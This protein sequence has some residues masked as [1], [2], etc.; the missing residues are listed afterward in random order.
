MVEHHLRGHHIYILQHVALLLH[1][2]GRQLTGDLALAQIRER[3]VHI[4][5]LVANI[6]H[7]KD[8]LLLHLRHLQ[9]IDCIL[10]FALSFLT[11]LMGDATV[12][13]GAVAVHQHHCCAYELRVG[14]AVEH[15]TAEHNLLLSQ[16]F[17]V[18]YEDVML[19][20]FHPDGL[21]L[22]HLVDGIGHRHVLHL[23]IDA[24]GVELLVDIVD[25]IVI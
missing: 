17:L 12:D 6:A 18:L 14:K 13:D 9:A 21:A 8:I 7:G 23:G 25:V 15:L 10:P 22:G 1:I 20:L 3:I 16:T 2:D 5:C 11:G 24:D 19:L 4:G